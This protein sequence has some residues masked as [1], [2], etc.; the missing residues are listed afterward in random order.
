[1][2]YNIVGTHLDQ[3]LGRDSVSNTSFS[4]NHSL[5]HSLNQNEEEEKVI[6]MEDWK[7]YIF[8]ELN[9]KNNV[10]IYCMENYQNI[11]TK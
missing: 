10:E 8:N 11:Q 3:I 7:K 5:N 9:L 6:F 1:M 4:L 2:K